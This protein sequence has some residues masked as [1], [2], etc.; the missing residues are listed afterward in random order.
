MTTVVIAAF[1]V[2]AWIYLLW[3]RAGFWRCAQRDDSDMAA[4]G[5]NIAWPSVVAIVPA[6]DEAA[7]IGESIRSLLRQ[8]YRGSFAIVVVDDHSS[9]D[10]AVIVRQMAAS[11][12]ARR[13]VVVVAAPTLP[14][15]WS[16]KLWAIHSGLAYV[17]KLARRPEFLLLT[18]ADIRHSDD[19][20]S[21]LVHRALR[22]RFVLTSLMARLRCVSFAE[23]A[24]VPAFVFFFQMLYP[25]AWVNRVDRSTAAA[26]GGCVLVERSALSVAGGIEAIRGELIDDCALARLLKRRGGPIWLGLGTRVA[27]ARAYASV[28]EIRRMVARSAYAQLGYSAWA[29]LGASAAMLVTFVAPPLLAIFARGV[30]QL[31]GVLG[32]ALMAVAFL[33]ML[34]FYRVSSRWALVLPA[35][36][37][38]YLAFTWD[39]VWQNVRG[40]GGTWKGRVHRSTP[41][42]ETTKHG[43]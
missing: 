8:D 6:R 34:R 26:A 10:T 12:D 9:D 40:K 42:P 20:L 21:S 18:D 35:I 13:E 5:E 24:L 41:E 25:F 19:S 32:W 28:G 15:G 14:E 30:P 23:H 1:A 38:A 22:G 16:G 36:A 4:A 2:A 11:G 39:S 3:A 37:A 43:G 31:L 17:D 29:L 33:P 27:S 7:M